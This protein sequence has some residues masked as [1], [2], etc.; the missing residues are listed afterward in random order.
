MR[1]VTRN[2]LTLVVLSLLLL[3]VANVGQAQAQGVLPNPVLYMTGQE[4]YQAGG[5]SFVRYR[6][7]VLNH[8]AYPNT[9]FAPSPNLPPC[10]ANT[11]SARTWVDIFDQRG[12]RLYGFCALR[13]H[14][15]L[16]SIWFA[17]PP[18]EVPPSW[19]YIEMK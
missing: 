18:D 14:N 11:R 17:I 16:N 7:A 15:D 2:M 1:S 4:Y 6:Y 12:K 10:G 3:V 19:I 8:D 5:R 13:S 9:L